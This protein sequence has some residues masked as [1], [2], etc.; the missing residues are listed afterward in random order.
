MMTTLT[1]IEI[2]IVLVAV[3]GIAL[4]VKEK[5]LSNLSK[6]LW[7]LFILVFN[8]IALAC[9]LVWKYANKCKIA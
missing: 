2:F 4:V 9:F 8:F 5:E 7:T 1:I 3:I 6:V